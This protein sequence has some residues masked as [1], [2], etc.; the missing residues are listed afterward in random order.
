MD[1]ATGTGAVLLPAAQQVGPKGH[2]TGIDLSSSM[3][4]KVKDTA[5]SNGL[6]NVDLL[7]MDAEKLD[8]PDAYF[9]AVTCGFGI[10]FFPDMGAA[11]REMY[12]VCKPG[13]F[14][15]ISVFDK[16]VPES[17]LNSKIL[18][19]QCQDY[20][21]E[22]IGSQPGTFSPEDFRSLVA[23][24]GFHSIRT[25]CETKKKVYTDLERLWQDRMSGGTSILLKNM[26]EDTYVRFK[27]EYLDKLHPIMESDGFHQLIAVIYLVAQR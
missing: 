20:K 16:T 13:G 2:V 22:L 14:V 12:R 25:Y 5:S 17:A 18:R 15:G 21:I 1:V 7:K 11:L 3:I 8:F 6:S 10:W 23:Q 26:D 4:Q 27:E 9:D 24:H 19:Q